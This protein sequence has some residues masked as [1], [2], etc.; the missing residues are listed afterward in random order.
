M[1]IFALIHLVPGVTVVR[2]LLEFQHVLAQLGFAQVS[3]FSA[4]REFLYPLHMA[5]DIV[6]FFH[7]SHHDHRRLVLLQRIVHA[8]QEREVVAIVR[9]GKPHVTPLRRRK[10][11]VTRRGKPAVYLVRNDA[12]ARIGFGKMLCHRQAVIR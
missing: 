4:E 6:E 12:N 5:G 2:A 9:I 8:L 10:P 3:V 11:R 7:M 1:Q